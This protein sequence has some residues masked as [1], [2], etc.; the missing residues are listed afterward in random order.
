V[1]EKEIAGV[2]PEVVALASLVVPNAAAI[3]TAANTV[4]EAVASA[5]SAS[6][7]AAEQN[8]LNAGVDQAAI[9]AAKAVVPAFQ[10]A[11]AK[12]KA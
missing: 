5:L 3:A 1:I 2:E 11:L 7:S 4:L 9:D 12:K 8:F 6:G 10:A